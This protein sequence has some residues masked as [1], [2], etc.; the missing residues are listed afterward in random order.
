M[1]R[2]DVRKSLPGFELQAHFDAPT[3]GV[4]ALFGRSGCGKTTTINLIAGLS[5]TDAGYVEL[6]GEVLADSPRRINLPPEQRRTGY[7]FQ[8]AR[9]F[10]HLSVLGNLRYGAR[11]ARTN[12]HPID[13][14]HI[15]NLLGLQTLLQRRPHQLSGGERQRVALGRALLSQPRLLLLDEPLASLDLARRDEVLPY[16]VALRDELAIPMVYVSH[17][18]AEVLQLATYVVLMDAGRVVA[19]GDVRQVS[20]APALRHVVGGEQVGAVLD[21][22]VTAAD[23]VAALAVVQIGD[24]RIT[25]NLRGAQTGDRLRLQ[26]LARDLVLATEEPRKLSLH[27]QLQG[28]VTAIAAEELDALLVQVDV[29]GAALLARVSREAGRTLAL[30]PGMP[31]WVLINALAIRGHV[32]K[33]GA[34]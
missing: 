17:Q 19:Q 20:L 24:T 12:T 25:V 33:L 10:P 3:P 21:G 18:F 5:G 30:T 14:E 2:V 9:L 15:V 23:R 27:N 29:G 34:Q 32:F 8:D 4:V 6:D 7:V 16:L 26:L 1:L 31:V 11:R 22:V 28:T 13:F